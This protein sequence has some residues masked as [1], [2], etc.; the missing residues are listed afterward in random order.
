[1]SWNGLTC[2]LEDSGLKRWRFYWFAGQSLVTRMVWITWNFD[3]I[4]SH[5]MALCKQLAKIG[6]SQPKKCMDLTPIVGTFHDPDHDVIFTGHPCGADQCPKAPV[7][8]LKSAR[9]RWSL[10]S[11]GPTKL[12]WAG[13]ELLISRG[14]RVPVPLQYHNQYPKKTCGGF[15][16][17]GYPTMEDL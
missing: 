16:K 12:Q 5:F 9:D 13:W 3:P 7:V 15:L 11:L 14:K 2:W 6:L 10:P 17:W 8:R 1:M 4:H